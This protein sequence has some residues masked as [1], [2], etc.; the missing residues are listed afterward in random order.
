MPETMKRRR[1]PYCTGTLHALLVRKLPK[2][3]DRERIH[4]VRLAEAVG[5]S[6]YG[7]HCWMRDDKLTAKAANALIRVARQTESDLTD[8][9]LLPFLLA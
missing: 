6:R 1:R 8:S 7:V 9:D 4:G 2:F 3:V 5:Y